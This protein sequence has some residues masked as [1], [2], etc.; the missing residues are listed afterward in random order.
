MRACDDDGEQHGGTNSFAG[1]SLLQHNNSK[2]HKTVLKALLGVVYSLEPATD[3]ARARVWQGVAAPAVRPRS[4]R[5]VA[6]QVDRGGGRPRAVRNA[7]NRVRRCN[8]LGHRL[9][10]TAGSR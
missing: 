3:D 4:A 6:A 5:Q 1:K 8:A 9:S 2:L 7:A 10:S